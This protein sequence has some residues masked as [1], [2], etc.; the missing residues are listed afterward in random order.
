MMDS[1]RNP[2]EYPIITKRPH[3]QN[4]NLEDRISN[5]PDALLCYI[6]SLV[7][8]ICAVRTTVLSKRWN[9]LWTYVD[10]YDFENPNEKHQHFIEFGETVLRNSNVLSIRRFRLSCS[11]GDSV[12]GISKLYVW[13]CTAVVRNVK[14]FDLSIRTKTPIEL[15]KILFTC[16]TLVSLKLSSIN[17]I[18]IPEIIRFS[19]LKILQI[20]HWK[21][22]V[23]DPM[24]NILDCSPVLEELYLQFV[25]FQNLQKLSLRC[26]TL[27]RLTISTLYPKP[28]KENLLHD[29][30]ID[31]PRLEYLN[32]EDSH[33]NGVEL[34]Q[35]P[36]LTS[37]NLHI[38]G[39]NLGVFEFLSRVS[40]VKHLILFLKAGM[41]VLPAPNLL[42]INLTNLEIH[43]TDNWEFVCSILKC[44]PNL[45]VLTCEKA[46]RC[47]INRHHA[48]ICDWRAPDDVPKCLLCLTRIEIKINGCDNEM[49]LVKY[50]LNNAMT[51]KMMVIGRSVN[52]VKKWESRILKELL[53]FRRGS[54]M[55]EVVFGS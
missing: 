31:T 44:S 39:L 32:F 51:L 54:V 20:R 7:P 35:L 26:F 25:V 5:L 45:Q 43:V 55:C 53:R 50:L 23:D 36:V 1:L 8:T 14:E 28:L 6:L 19:S 15:P 38:F 40:N 11:W 30:V 22:M 48:S 42:L 21:C 10:N 9:T 52:F 49:E 29:V 33:S 18:T 13:I 24:K 17:F 47:S 12:H 4:E 16:E 34:N 37:A 27:K 41:D 2:E 3:S 46:V